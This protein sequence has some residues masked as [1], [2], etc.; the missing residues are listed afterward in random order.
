MAT[1]PFTSADVRAGTGRSLLLAAGL[2]GGIVPLSAGTLITLTNGSQVDGKLSISGSAIHAEGASTSDIALTDVL[3]ARFGDAPFSLN[4]F[5]AD[6]LSKLP[7]DWVAQDIGEADVHGSVTVQDGAFTVSGSVASHG[8]HHH[9]PDTYFFA[10]VPWTS[11]GQFTARLASVDAQNIIMDAGLI[12]R[13]SLDSD[14]PVCGAVWNSNGMLRLPFR[15]EKGR[16]AAG[17]ETKA[18]LPVWLRF[19][20]LGNT[21]L[22]ST[23]PDGN[24]WDFIAVSP[25][26]SLANPFVGLAARCSP[27]RQSP[28]GGKAVFDNISITPLPSTAQVLPPGVVLKGGSLLAGRFSRALFDP[29]AAEDNPQFSRGGKPIKI[30]RSTIA[31]ALMLP[32]DRTKLESAGANPSVLMRNG[33]STD[34]DVTEISSDQVSVSSVLLGITTYRATEVRAC[35]LQPVQPQSGAFE[36]R[37]RD[38]SILNA[39]GVS[40]SGDDVVI[41]DVSGLSIQAS[42]AEVAQVRAGSSLVQD[43]AQLPWKATPTAGSPPPAN[44]A[45]PP[46][47]PAPPLVQSW[48]G[49]D[50][51]QILETAAG[52]AVEFSMPAKSRA[53]GVQVALASDSPQN[54]TLT[55]RILADGREVAKSPAFRVG[56]GP[57]FL[58]LNVQNPAHVT[59]QAE[60][61]FP[62]AKVLY[63]DPV[64]IRP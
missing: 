45:G 4:I 32:L 21:V 48:L 52:T 13:D 42:L 31:A 59:L 62:G 60:S 39:T 57:R 61:I 63:I 2:L 46:A 36:V 35:F 54:A 28:T 29:T 5:S 17:E 16:Y 20:R 58:E 49:N 50:Q 33:D 41:T 8:A 22:T 9:A 40:S 30:P 25:F 7:P 1:F 51:E 3:E 6:K 11:D 12:L 55:L 44:G 19:T 43:L 24:A 26:A 38:G 64:A 37:L 27:T 10:G 34:G 14:A 15:R 23:S 47:N 56:D 53:F 18:D